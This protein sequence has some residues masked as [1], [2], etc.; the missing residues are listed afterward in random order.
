MR[1]REGG[2]RFCPRPE[3]LELCDLLRDRTKV[4][5]SLDG[6][7]R[8]LVVD[9]VQE[10]SEKVASSLLRSASAAAANTCTNCLSRG[11]GPT[12]AP[13]TEGGREGECRE[14]PV[15]PSEWTRVS[16]VRARRRV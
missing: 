11:S 9:G 1:S 10:G 16:L 4:V 13:R 3:V 6:L 8:F 15:T 2:P 7:Q 14:G 5:L 12:R